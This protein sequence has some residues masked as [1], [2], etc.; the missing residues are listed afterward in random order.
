M[1]QPNK[2]HSDMLKDAVGYLRNTI[3]LPLRFTRK[4]SKISFLFAELNSGGAVL[5][6]FHNHSFVEGEIVDVPL[7]KMHPDSLANLTD[8]SHAPPNKKTAVRF[9]ADATSTS[10]T[11]FR[12]GPS[13]NL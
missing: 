2:L 3:P 10:V 6:E 1:H 9:L 12:G 7:C 4:P 11:S 13:C 5:S 8:S